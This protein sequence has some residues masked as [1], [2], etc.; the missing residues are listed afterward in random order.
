MIQ[1]PTNNTKVMVV[2]KNITKFWLMLINPFYNLT[3]KEIGLLEKLIE[4]YLSFYRKTKDENLS[5]EFLFSTKNRKKII[6]ELGI[7][8]TYFDV[9]LHNLREHKIINENKIIRSIL[10]KITENGS[11]NLL[12][13]FQNN[14]KE[15]A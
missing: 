14:E 5:N 2:D 15:L 9:L 12:I 4:S 10:P 8:S 13:S 1:I 7:S 3:N 6:S 11:F